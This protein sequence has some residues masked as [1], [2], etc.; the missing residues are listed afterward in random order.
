MRHVQDRSAGPAWRQQHGNAWLPRSCPILLSISRYSSASVYHILHQLACCG[1]NPSF[2]R[3]CRVEANG[4]HIGAPSWRAQQR[5]L[6]AVDVC[7]LVQ[8]HLCLPLSATPSALPSHQPAATGR[9]LAP[10]FALLCLAEKS[11]VYWQASCSLRDSSWWLCSG[12]GLYGQTLPGDARHTDRHSQLQGVSCL[13]AATTFTCL[14]GGHLTMRFC[15]TL[16]CASPVLWYHFQIPWC[17]CH[18]GK[19]K[20]RCS[21]CRLLP[22]HHVA[23]ADSHNALQQTENTSVGGRSP[24]M[25]SP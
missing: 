24:F 2:A 19:L 12:I 6:G 13:L 3:P 5:S 10:G 21:P 11:P 20:P 7:P 9:F 14:C 25:V 4:L 8:G 15:C 22:K 23:D 16:A 17:T 18:L 1:W